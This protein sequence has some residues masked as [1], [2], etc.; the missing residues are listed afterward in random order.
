MASF[1]SVVSGVRVTVSDETAELLDSEWEPADDET[2]KSRT[3]RN[4]KK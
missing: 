1:R 4:S 3:S 2:S